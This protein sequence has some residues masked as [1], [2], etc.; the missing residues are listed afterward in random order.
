MGLLSTLVFGRKNGIRAR[1]K[2]VILG[3]EQPEPALHEYGLRKV[4]LERVYRAVFENDAMRRL[5]KM[6][7]GMNEL[8]LLGKAFDLERERNRDGSPTW[9]MVIVDAPA[10]GHGVSLLRLPQAILDVIKS[11]PMAEEV[12]EMRRLLVDPERTMLNVVTLPEEMPVR[13]T[14]ELLGQVGTLLEIPLGWLL[15]NG[16]W[17]AAPDASLSAL[18]HEL[19]AAGDD[20]L[21]DGAVACLDAQ[22]RRR[23][24]QQSYLDELHESLPD[25][26]IIELP[27]LFTR[28]FGA[29]AI[30]TL[31]DGVTERAREIDELA[32]ERVA[33]QKEHDKHADPDPAAGSPAHPPAPASSIQTPRGDLAHE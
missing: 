29:A 23:G 16:V 11:G 19:A 1:L 27:F 12:R 26:R 22:T 8:L 33:E 28:D 3:G 5:L 30:E 20:P 6:I 13:E 2:R 21:V 17:P 7:P 31:A 15:I 10:T 14:F 4:R 32:K 24:F 9:D 25:L 18:A